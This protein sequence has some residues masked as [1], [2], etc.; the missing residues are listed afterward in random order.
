MKKAGYAGLF[1]IVGVLFPILIWVGLVVAA[2]EWR[3]QTAL[4]KQ[5]SRP[6]SEILASA[7]IQVTSGD[8]SL[9]TAM[10]VRRPQ[11]EIWDMLRRAGI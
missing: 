8:R 4:E 3:R 7:G 2:I 5:P 9:A 6:I 1:L 10:F 11:P